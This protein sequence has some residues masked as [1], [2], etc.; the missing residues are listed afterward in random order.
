MEVPAVGA[1]LTGTDFSSALS[2]LAQPKDRVLAA[3]EG[4]AQ[5][6]D[7]IAAMLRQVSAS[8]VL[9][10]LEI[11]ERPLSPENAARLEG[12]LR[13]SVAA[14]AEGNAQQALSSLAEFAALDPRRAG[15]LES[16]PG[17]L[18]IRPEVRQLLSQLASAAHLDAESRLGQATQLL[19]ATGSRK[20]PGEEFSPEIAI[21]I[22]GRL[23]EAGGYANWMR[24][25]EL[26]Q[27]AINL[28]AFAPVPAPPP[29]AAQR[30]FPIPSGHA[31]PGS[32]RQWAPSIRWLWRRGPLLVLL[33]AWLAIGL[34]GGS[35]SAMWRIYWPQTWPQ[36]LSD[37]GFD[38]WGIGFLALI[39]F[40]FYA[41][42]RNWRR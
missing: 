6:G 25:A 12:L 16:E 4:A 29:L 26:S 30:R 17:L 27:M 42:V 31:V 15:T 19:E 11:I 39:G 2:G 8:A 34:V 18:S 36:S 41:K 1:A 37:I 35:V 10:L 38:V 5:S 21:M 9:E 28:Y 3:L 7:T 23:L 22:A 20:L 33:L 24:S 14:A 40:G 32:R 13:A